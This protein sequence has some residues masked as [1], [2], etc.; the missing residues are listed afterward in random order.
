MRKFRMVVSAIAVV[1]GMAASAVAVPVDVSWEDIWKPDGGSKLL[2]LW[3]ALSIPHDITDEGYNSDIDTVSSATLDLSFYDGDQRAEIVSIFI[4]DE[5]VG[6]LISANNLRLESRL[7]ITG[8]ALSFLDVT[9]TLA[10][11]VV[12]TAGDISFV[13]S[14]LTA[15]GTHED[16]A[17]TTSVP[18]AASTM[19]LLGI[20]MIWIGGFVGNRTKKAVK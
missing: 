14:K 3:E 11:T 2:H 15:S 5:F 10:V 1:L 12:D 7:D 19:S 6:G 8:D 17:L 20:A 16:G 18:D 9:G 4:D 13:Q